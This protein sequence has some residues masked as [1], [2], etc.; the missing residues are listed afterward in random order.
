MKAENAEANAV[1]ADAL[2]RGGNV[3]AAK[4]RVD[5]VIAYDPGNATALRARAE[6]ELRT[7]NTKEAIDDAQKLVT[8]LPNSPSDRLLLAKAFT[9]A[10]DKPWADR[11]LWAAFKDIPGNDSIYAALRSS[12]SGNPEALADLQAEF[13]RQRDGQVRKGLL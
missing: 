8:V 9:A 1:L 12:R 7:G 10:G 6:L 13:D 4:S 11:T 5:A 3:A 2:S